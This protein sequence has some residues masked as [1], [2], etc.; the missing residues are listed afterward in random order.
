V[1]RHDL[2]L[3][4]T[5]PVLAV[6]ALVL[7]SAHGSGQ[8]RI[9]ERQG[10]VLVVGRPGALT[11]LNTYQQQLTA[12]ERRV[13]EPFVPMVIMNERTTLSD[14]FTPCMTVT[15]DGQ[16]FY[17]QRDRDGD[18]LGMGTAGFQQVYHHV[19]LR[20][21][22]VRVL[23]GQALRVRSADGLS[24]LLLDE[25][26]VLRRMFELGENTY[27]RLSVDSPRYGWVNLA[28]RDRGRIWEVFS[29]RPV[30][31]SLS[32]ALIEKVQAE[33]RH[34]NETLRKLFEFFNAQT[35]THRNAPQWQLTT[36]A[37]GLVCVLE[38]ESQQHR[39]PQST[40]QLIREIES[41]LI[42]TGYAVGGSDGRIEV[43]RRPLPEG[44][45]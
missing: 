28:D 21:D 26:E 44:G 16:S 20:G 10:D 37:D 8:T 19:G 38:G 27:V 25:G 5:G 45:G 13:L 23:I 30:S 43:V 24:S 39:F 29:P 3:T 12:A 41:I 11:I 6:A 22:S 35:G 18:L 2:W 14:G 15:I 4:R 9:R 1:K 17:L 36:A 33:V 34:V 42:G 32:V 7:V 40:R 31:A